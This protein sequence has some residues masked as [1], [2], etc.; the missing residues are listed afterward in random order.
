MRKREGNEL[1][2][3]RIVLIGFGVWGLRLKMGWDLRMRKGMGKGMGMRKEEKKIST[4]L[5]FM[6]TGQIFHNL[7]LYFLSFLPLSPYKIN[8]TNQKNNSLSFSFSLL[9]SRYTYDFQTKQLRDLSLCDLEKNKRT[10]IL[11]K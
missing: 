3:F 7:I 9:K 11:K 2:F 5:V 8:S 1:F 10:R 4:I 6:L